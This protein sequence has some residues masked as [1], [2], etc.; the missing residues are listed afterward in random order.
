MAYLSDEVFS[1][2]TYSK[3][4][5]GSRKNPEGVLSFR[6]GGLSKSLGLP[7]LKL[8][9]VL[10]DGPAQ[11]VGECHERLE[12][13]ADSYLSVNTP[14]QI[15]LPELLK[16]APGIQKQIL[17]RVLSNRKV[18]EGHFSGMKLAKVWPAQGGWYAL[19]ERTDARSR[20]EDWILGLIKKHRVLV[21]PGGFY[22]FSEGC[23]AVLSL[24]PRPE[25]FAEGV[26]RV[27][28]SIEEG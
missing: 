27:K 12:L 11:L 2:Y 6:M 15:A 26:V 3:R 17:D 23:F 24:L 9:W 28:R 1:E 25:I 18:L 16:F 5:T 14:V 22:D 8:A 21:Q 20:E 13:I 7:Q 19:M 4:A 10:M